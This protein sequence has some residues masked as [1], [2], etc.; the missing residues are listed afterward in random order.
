MRFTL[1][2]SE[3]RREFGEIVAAV[4]TERREF[5]GH[6]HRGRIAILLLTVAVETGWIIAVAGELRRIVGTRA[7]VQGHCSR[8]SRNSKLGLSFTSR[9]RSV[10]N[11]VENARLVVNAIIPQAVFARRTIHRL[12][13][14]QA[15]LADGVVPR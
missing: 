15:D 2:I 7:P 1:P 4:E 13:Q 14:Q 8:R 3:V 5:W 9:I 11:S 12:A 6:E 10:V